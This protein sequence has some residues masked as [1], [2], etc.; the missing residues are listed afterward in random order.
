MTRWIRLNTYID[1][2]LDLVLW[3]SRG[4]D[5]DPLVFISHFNKSFDFLQIFFAIIFF[6]FT[7]Y[8]N[9][10]NNSS[11]SADITVNIIGQ[12]DKKG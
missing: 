1:V 8:K 9:N 3:P 2:L 5:R 11:D 7:F 10:N 12:S 6:L 4:V